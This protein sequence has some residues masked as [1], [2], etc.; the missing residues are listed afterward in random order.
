MLTSTESIFAINFYIYPLAAAVTWIPA[1]YE[2]I[3]PT[4]VHWLLFGVFILCNTSAVLLFLG[5]LRHVDATLA[6]TLDYFTLVWVLV[7]GILIW[8]EYPDPVSSI[9]I[10]FIVASGIYIVRHSTRR[11]DESIVQSTEH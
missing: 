5:G 9:G 1:Q 6:A 3:T 8:R 2:W 11:I 7:L 10:L 4:P